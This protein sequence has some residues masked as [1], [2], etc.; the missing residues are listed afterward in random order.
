M[1]NR[2]E[3]IQNQIIKPKNELIKTLYQENVEL[4]KELSKQTNLVDT[5]SEFV[6]EKR[7]MSMENQAFRKGKF[8]LK[9]N[10]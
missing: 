1:M 5:A 7:K 8:K 4:H 9:E 2:D 10:G 6:K 3:K